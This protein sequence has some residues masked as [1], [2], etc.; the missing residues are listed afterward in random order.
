MSGAEPLPPPRVHREEVKGAAA[1]V[2]VPTTYAGLRGL[3]NRIEVTV[4]DG[5]LRA[6]HRPLPWLVPPT[7]CT[8][9]IAQLFVADLA[10]HTTHPSYGL[11][12]RTHQGREH[13][14]FAVPDLAVATYF[15]TQIERALGIEDRPVRGQVGS[16]ETA[17]VRDGR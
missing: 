8:D 16:V 1:A 2:V 9:D 17:P 13:L 5:A 4:V 11:R 6:R 3:V 7:L 10:P 15:E 12:V 14:L